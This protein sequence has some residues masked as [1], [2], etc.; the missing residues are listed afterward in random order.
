MLFC[1]VFYRA[2]SLLPIT[3]VVDILRL[4]V[5]LS[6]Q[7][8][9]ERFYPFYLEVCWA[10]GFVICYNADADSLTAAIPGLPRYNRPLSLPFFGWLYLAVIGTE[11]ITDNKVIVDVLWTG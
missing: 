10:G 6:G 9:Y 7:C 3:W 11:A 5:K 8:L 1:L 2:L 4:N